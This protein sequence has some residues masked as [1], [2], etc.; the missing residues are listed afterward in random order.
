MP[1]SAGWSNYDSLDFPGACMTTHVAVMPPTKM[2]MVSGNRLIGAAK[3]LMPKAKNKAIPNIIQ[4]KIMA[5]KRC[6]DVMII[7]L[8]SAVRIYD[9]RI[10]HSRVHPIH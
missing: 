8:H 10:T 3:T 1:Y 5:V 7:S 4:M 2:S 9:L 6:S